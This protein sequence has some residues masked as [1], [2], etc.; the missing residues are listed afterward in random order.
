M[1]LP[2]GLLHAFGL[3]DSSQTTRE[4]QTQENPDQ[5]DEHMLQPR[6]ARNGAR[7]Q[8]P[9]PCKQRVTRCGV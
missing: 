6:L 1:E 3:S 8:Q 9:Q 4:G 7:D 5:T 2:W